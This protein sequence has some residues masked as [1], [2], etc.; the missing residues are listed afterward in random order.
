ML[1][2]T[3]AFLS[4]LVLPVLAPRASAAL[5][6]RD[7][8]TPG[9]G[10]LTLDTVTGLE[11]LDFS[12]SL[13]RAPL[14][15]V[16][17]YPGFRM[18]YREEV[19]GL[20]MSAGIAAN[21]INTNTTHLVDLAAG[22]L[23][24]D[25]IG[26]TISAFNGAVAQISGRV[27]RPNNTQYDVYFLEIRTSPATPQGTSN[28]FLEFGNSLTAWQSGHADFLVRQAVPEPASLAL[29][30]VSLLLLGWRARRS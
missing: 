22:H 3:F 12:V 2:R 9:D 5:V 6:V 18:A 7:W 15:A 17:T 28:V 8:S 29:V 23:L 14:A 11:W 26:V 21:R 13:G 30:G 20:L 27:L 24:R 25:T 4:L 19:E 1:L 16:A 10:L